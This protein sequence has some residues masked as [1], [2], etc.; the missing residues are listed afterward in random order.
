LYDPSL[1]Q[2][3]LPYRIVYRAI[4][5]TIMLLLLLLKWSLDFH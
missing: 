5:A 2:Q 1:N 3:L 4:I